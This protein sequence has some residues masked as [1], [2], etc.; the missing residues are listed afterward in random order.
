MGSPADPPALPDRRGTAV[1][2]EDLAWL[3]CNR[4]GAM[5]NEVELRAAVDKV[6]ALQ[7]RTIVEIGC[8]NGGT[9]WVWRQLGAEVLAITLPNRNPDYPSR[10]GA[11][12]CLADSH[13]PES[14]AWLRERLDGRPVDVLHID[15]DH[16]YDGVRADL[17]TYVPLVRPGGLVLLHDIVNDRDAADVGRLWAEIRPLWNRTEEIAA[18]APRPLGFGLI[19][20]DNR[21][22]S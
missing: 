14:V 13:L 21:R 4:H 1:N 20:I 6:A 11:T 5:Q 22:T 7:P 17:E 8:G 18:A 2:G 16:S 10:H 15:G 3:A 9:L 12:V 19:W